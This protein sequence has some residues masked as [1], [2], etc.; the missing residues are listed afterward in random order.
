[1]QYLEAPKTVTR[2]AYQN[3]QYLDGIQENALKLSTRNKI[4]HYLPC[5]VAQKE[6]IPGLTC[7]AFVPLK[8][9]AR[10]QLCITLYQHTGK[11]HIL[12]GD[13]HFRH[14]HV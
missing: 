10:P 13:F 12:T 1:M 14:K 3:F 6:A 9:Q 8:N 2:A 11:I 7:S 5:L 4:K